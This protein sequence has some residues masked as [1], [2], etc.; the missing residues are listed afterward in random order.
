MFFIR[1]KGQRGERKLDDAWRREYR[2]QE[3]ERTRERI[4]NQ[5][6]RIPQGWTNLNDMMQQGGQAGENP[7]TYNP[8]DNLQV[9]PQHSERIT[10]SASSRKMS[11]N[12]IRSG[13]NLVNPSLISTEFG[14]GME[15]PGRGSRQGNHTAKPRTVS[16]MEGERSGKHTEGERM[17]KRADGERDRRHTEGE[18]TGKRTER[19]RDGRRKYPERTKKNLENKER[20]KRRRNP[21]VR[22]KEYT[23]KNRIKKKGQNPEEKEKK[24]T[25]KRTRPQGRRRPLPTKPIHKTRPP[26]PS[27][28]SVLMEKRKQ[29]RLEK[30]KQKESKDH[31]TIGMRKRFVICL[32]C[33]ICILLVLSGAV[34]RLET[35]HGE[36]YARKVLT[37]KRYD[38]TILPYRRGDIVDANGTILA[39]SEEVYNVVLD[40]S[41]LKKAEATLEETEEEE[42]EEN[43]FSKAIARLKGMLKKKKTE[44]ETKKE[45][46][47]Y[48]KTTAQ[49]LGQAFSE[50]SE[51]EFEAMLTENESS[52]YYR[53]EKLRKIT[54][55]EKKAFEDLIE[56][57]D[58]DS[59]KEKDVKKY[60]TGVWFEK[61]YQRIYPND[62]LAC[63]IVGFSESGNVG[64]W[65]V[66][67]SYNSDLNGTDGTQYYYTDENS[68]YHSVIK[69]AEDG[70]SI[71]LT[72]DLNIQ[73]VVENKIED[74]LK[75]HKNEARDGDGAE[76][77]AVVVMNPNTGEIL[78]MADKTKYDPNHAHSLYEVYG[79]KTVD[80]WK[81]EGRVNEDGEIIDKTK[82]SD[83]KYTK[84]NERLYSL[85]RNSC[86]SD[87][88]EAGSTIKP[89]TV[90]TGLELGVLTG[91]E[92]F[93]CDGGE[94][95]GQH[96]VKCSN[97]DGHG[98]IT[99]QQALMVSCNDALMDIAFRIG[100][101]NFTKYQSVFNFG[102]KTGVDLPGEAYTANLLYSADEMEDIDLAT[103]SFGQNFNVTMLQVAAG[104][105]SLIN[106]GSYYK[107][108]IAKKILDSNGGVV[109]SSDPILIKQTVSTETSEKLK[110]YLQATASEGTGKTAK[111]NGYSMG[112]K[113][114]TAEVYPRGKGNYLVSFIGHAPAD[115]P[116]VVVYCIVDKPNVDPQSDSKLAQRV[117]KGIMTEILPYLGIYQDEE[118]LAEDENG[119]IIPGVLASEVEQEDPTAQGET[120]ENPTAQGETGEEPTAQG[121][122]GENPTAQGETGEE[123]ASQGETGENPPA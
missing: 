86:V 65:G 102:L 45:K 1:E 21:S 108:H 99:L 89:F 2:R 69:E 53:P 27:L 120:G 73:K 110:T 26:K 59:E 17:V 14:G 16:H 12:Q 67:G 37:Q 10:S 85:W 50:Y 72:M 38:T 40:C 105:S 121:E 54:Y 80:R 30:K 83:D 7:Q 119:T 31:I 90:A 20:R 32:S 48:I 22:E 18:R 60:V 52:A 79:K 55:Q 19:N 46:R 61:E 9:S 66:E 44:Q 41:Q 78:A 112:G 42:K 11:P 101:E 29:R 88:Y 122:T 104:Y 113:T 77:I 100:K 76:N 107:P 103:N 92:E 23:D 51:A 94:Q 24:R 6:G 71:E 74:F 75:E 62:S 56:K 111:V 114:G 64:T 81:A 70:N 3:L 39:T 4:R 36:E 84:I 33:I 115:H 96:Y 117:V 57:D 34:L 97:H 118:L 106:G 28:W 95:V 35:V 93:V 68:N 109:K 87:T 58:S 91:D 13:G 8:N 25:R 116:E 15:K 43:F 98:K 5:T 123:P 47:S 49:V 63:K 82:F